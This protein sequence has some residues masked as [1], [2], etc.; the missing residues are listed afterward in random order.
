MK[1]RNYLLA[2][3]LFVTASILSFSS[4]KA[5]SH[6]MYCN[7]TSAWYTDPCEPYHGC[8]NEA[9]WP[10]SDKCYAH[11]GVPEVPQPPGCE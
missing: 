11:W 9:A 10:Y 6:F 3:M 7:Y 5:Q 1:K 2:A 4:P 8:G